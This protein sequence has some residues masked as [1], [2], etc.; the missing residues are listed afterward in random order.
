MLNVST[1]L[2]RDKLENFIEY[3]NRKGEIKN[4][5]PFIPVQR[6]DAE[7]SLQGKQQKQY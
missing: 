2:S 6:R 3:D 1:Y 5:D 4:C 7:N